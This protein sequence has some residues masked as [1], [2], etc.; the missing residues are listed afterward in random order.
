MT[1]ED[2]LDYGYEDTVVFENPDYGDSIIGVDINGRAIYSLQK[3]AENLA[4]EDHMSYEDAVD[5]IDY[6]AAR[7]LSYVE[8]GPIIADIFEG[9]TNGRKLK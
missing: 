8:D 1:K 7:S 2:L 3:M 9:E 5:F 6:N 4:A